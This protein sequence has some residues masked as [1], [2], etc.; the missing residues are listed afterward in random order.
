[1]VTQIGAMS[2]RGFKRGSKLGRQDRRGD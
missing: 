2:P 1:M